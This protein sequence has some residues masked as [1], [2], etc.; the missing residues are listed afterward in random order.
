M[1]RF[2]CLSDNSWM[3]LELVSE[4][5]HSRNLWKEFLLA[6]TEPRRFPRV[7]LTAVVMLFA[8][9]AHG[10]EPPAPSAAVLSGLA[11]HCG[12]VDRGAPITVH[13]QLSGEHRY[14]RASISG[15]LDRSSR[16]PEAIQLSSR[17][18]RFLER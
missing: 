4:Y 3:P 18:R 9:A 1:I 8:F 16:R 11:P 15:Y 2:S 14:G 10:Q 13:H 5:P 17:I 7:L 12:I 6:V